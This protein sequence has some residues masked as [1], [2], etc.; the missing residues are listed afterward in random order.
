MTLADLRVEGFASSIDGHLS[1]EK[2][3]TKAG[4]TTCYVT[5]QADNGLGASDLGTAALGRWAAAIR[6][7]FY[8]EASISQAFAH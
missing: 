6:R 8:M 5:T 3:G 4:Q 2:G 1:R 7:F